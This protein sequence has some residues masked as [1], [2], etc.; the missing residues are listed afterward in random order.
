MKITLTDKHTKPD[1]MSGNFAK[2]RSVFLIIRDTQLMQSCIE[3][4]RHC[5]CLRIIRV[6]VCGYKLDYAVIITTRDAGELGG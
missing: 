4:Q 3:H 2:D 1:K 5:F 6:R